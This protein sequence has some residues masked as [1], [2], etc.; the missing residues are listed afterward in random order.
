MMEYLFFLLNFPSNETKTIS[1]FFKDEY[2]F[3]DGVIKKPSLNLI[4]M[5]P[6]LNADSFLL[7]SIFEYF[8]ISDA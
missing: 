7:L 1:L 3:P 2:F 4:D 6:D 5:L 8:I